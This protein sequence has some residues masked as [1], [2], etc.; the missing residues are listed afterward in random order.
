MVHSADD[1][2]SYKIYIQYFFWLCLDFSKNWFYLALA[3]WHSTNIQKKK[4]FYNWMKSSKPIQKGT[5]PSSES[6]DDDK[7]KIFFSAL[8][9]TCRELVF[10]REIFGIR[11]CWKF[12]HRCSS[13]RI[14]YPES[15]IFFPRTV[16]EI[17]TN[18]F[19]IN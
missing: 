5:K 4:F 13:G 7:T 3:T 9:G 14:V 1:F 18:Y 16:R 15:F 10:I 11:S 8:G 6:S 12:Y 2:R 19:L 17:F